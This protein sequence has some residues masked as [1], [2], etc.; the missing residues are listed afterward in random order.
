MVDLPRPILAF[1][2]WCCL[3]GLAVSAGGV[4]L[5]ML[6]PSFCQALY[7]WLLA[8]ATL[9][10][11]LPVV[12]ARADLARSREISH[13]DKEI[14]RKQFHFGLWAVVASFFYLLRRDRRM[15]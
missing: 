4:F 2:G 12:L 14:W 6:T 11:F 7:P 15:R 13:T 9:C 8:L 3:S 5:L 1:V 10:L